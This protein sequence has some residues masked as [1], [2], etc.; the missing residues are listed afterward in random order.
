MRACPD[1]LCVVCRQRRKVPKV[2]VHKFD[3]SRHERE[4]N[5]SHPLFLHAPLQDEGRLPRLPG[6]L[7]VHAPTLR[8]SDFQSSET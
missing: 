5:S 8:Q 3:L 7:V 2:C 1:H 6:T 4:G